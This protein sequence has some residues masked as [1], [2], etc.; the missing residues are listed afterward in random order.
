MC[1][2]LPISI[3]VNMELNQTN[4][5]RRMEQ[6]SISTNNQTKQSHATTIYLDLI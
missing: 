3:I 6:V 4:K 2:R 1:R 5:V